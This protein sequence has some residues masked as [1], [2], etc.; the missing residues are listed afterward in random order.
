MATV[1]IGH[2]PWTARDRSPITGMLSRYLDL[3]GHRVLI[4][5]VATIIT[6]GT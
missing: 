1:Y 6:H 5:R 2:D 3:D 4:Y